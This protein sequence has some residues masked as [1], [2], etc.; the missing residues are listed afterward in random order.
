[1]KHLIFY[2]IFM[3]VLTL[4]AG[5]AFAEQPDEQAT[6]RIITLEEC[7][8]TGIRDNP[9]LEASRFALKAAGHDIKVARAD[10]LPSISSSYSVN[11]LENER[12]KGREDTDFINQ[13]IKTFNI[14]LTQ[15]L[16]AG[17]RIVNT[18]S[19]AKT[20][21]KMV[22]AEMNLEKLELIY[23][24]ETTFYRLMKAK[25]DM[26][27]A[28]ESV[29]RLT[30]SVNSAQAF[31]QK[32]LVPYVDVLQ[33]RVDL[34]DS[35]QLLGVAKNNV[36]REREGLF[37]LM[38]QPVDSSVQFQDSPYATLT[39]KFSFESSFQYA[40]KN[41][42]DLES[43][44]HQLSIARKEEKISMSRYMPVVRMDIGYNDQNRDFDEPG[45]SGSSTFDR[46]QR[47]RYYSAGVN[48]TWD[49][50]DGGKAWYGKEKFKAEA[51]RIKAL[52]KEAQNMIS[53]GIR[54][55]LY[56]MSE[57]EVRILDSDDAL[58]AAKENY[59]AQENRLRAGVSTIPALLD[60]QDRLV[61]AQVNKNRAILDYQLARSE[62][63][64]MTGEKNLNSLN[65]N[66]ETI[67]E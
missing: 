57:A 52:I 51:K 62:L 49:L 50:F 47:N 28:G 32:E 59:A 53:T 25:Q 24:I 22:K 13:E 40:L 43:L 29:N 23:N 5:S 39:E 3:I 48:I 36:N 37:T 38:N 16:Y 35:K 60:A 61:R 30:E 63:K 64:L 46:D 7:L 31:F 45:G 11:H 41:R 8:A 55:A 27:A 67:G 58:M 1:M 14:K 44:A 20:R 9:T 2:P 56:A 6:G 15:I 42:P 34:A 17:S 26:I 54:K 18:Y 10:F 19:K 66:L 4:T 33:A 12:A 65:S 21:E